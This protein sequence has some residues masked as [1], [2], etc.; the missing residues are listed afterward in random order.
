MKRVNH[1]L[2]LIAIISMLFISGCGGDK[3]VVPPT[4][5]DY[6]FELLMSK[7][8]VFEVDGEVFEFTLSDW[9]ES[10]RNGQSMSKANFGSD[11]TIPELRQLY[12]VLL[13]NWYFPADKYDSELRCEFYNNIKMG[14]DTW[15]DEQLYS[16]VGY[17]EDLGYNVPNSPPP[18]GPC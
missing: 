12:S 4:S 18:N 2:I 8:W 13:L 15:S 14:V 5:T 1:F 6:L 11:M 3:I 9:I 10:E 16:L 17:L 7:T